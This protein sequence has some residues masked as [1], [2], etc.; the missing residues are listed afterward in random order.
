MH[1]I[2]IYLYTSILLI[3][4]V[5]PLINNVV[6]SVILVV[7]VFII[8]FNRNFGP[9]FED[10][11]YMFNSFGNVYELFLDFSIEPLWLAIIWLFDLL[12]LDVHS[13]IG[14]IA[15]MSFSLRVLAL[16][17]FFKNQPTYIAIGLLVYLSNDFVIKDLGQIRSGISASFMLYF[18]ALYLHD[19][20]VPSYVAAVSSVLLHYSYIIP[21]SLIV[22]CRK[23]SPKSF[24]MIV[25]LVA[26]ALTE[27]KGIGS[28][29]EIIGFD[30]IWQYTQ[31]DIYL[32]R[33]EN[34]GFIYIYLG[35][36]VSILGLYAIRQMTYENKVILFVYTCALILFPILY[37]Y[38]VLAS[39][40]PTTILSLNCIL[41]P[42]V[43]QRMRVKSFSEGVVYLGV[44][45]PLFFIGLYYTLNYFS[46]YH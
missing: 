42:I 44:A 3:A 19:R 18:A 20:R 4:L 41:I 40:V 33:N 6:I 12:N 35:T 22:L 7:G 37:E 17:I 38:P 9:D 5:S 30:K 2:L 34:S 24:Y 27:V 13:R 10:Y 14:I 28:L 31:Y 23:I 15:V 16:R 1:S 25:A 29:L 46:H 39:R 21:I 36:I 45:A 32:V 11:L 8:S 43:L 26:L